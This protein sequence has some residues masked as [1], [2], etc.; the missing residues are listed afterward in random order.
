MANQENGKIDYIEHP[1][2]DLPVTKAFYAAAFGW[3]FQDWGDSYCDFN[4]GLQGGFSS[5][6]DGPKI[7]LVI[8]YA[9]DLE[10]MQAKVEAAGGALVKP[11]FSFPGGRRFHFKD[12]AGNEL[13]VWSET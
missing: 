4:E 1:G 7:P 10:G 3:K 9:K 2:G 11:I 8:I 5:D 6:P 12:P 13:A